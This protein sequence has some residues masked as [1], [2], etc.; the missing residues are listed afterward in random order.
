M[1]FAL[2]EDVRFNAAE[3]GATLALPA[4]L[5]TGL[6]IA[7]REVLTDWLEDA[8]GIDTVM[9]FSPRRWNV[10]GA[11]RI[12]GVF[13][14]GKETATWLIV[15]DGSGWMLLRCR[16]SFVSNLT[17]RLADVLRLIDKQCGG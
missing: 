5:F 8:D 10:A 17:I 16:D 13:E 2:S 6:D 11:R 15:R 9:D 7:D 14:A 12:L 1:T 4:G 3:S